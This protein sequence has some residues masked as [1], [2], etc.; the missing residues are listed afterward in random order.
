MSVFDQSCGLLTQDSGSSFFL[1]AVAIDPDLDDMGMIKEAVQHC[2]C[3]CGIVAEGLLHS[4]KLSVEVRITVFIRT[5]WLS[6]GRRDS[7]VLSGPYIRRIGGNN[8]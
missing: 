3:Q 5:V 2:R 1:E 6:P 8:A 7:P 4:P